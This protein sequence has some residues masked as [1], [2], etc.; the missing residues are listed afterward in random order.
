MSEN[1]EKTNYYLSV[2]K[3]NGLSR[4]KASELMDTLSPEKIEKIEN[5]KQEPTPADIM[6]MAKGYGEPSI[7]NYYCAHDCPMGKFYVREI[8]IKELEKTVLQMIASLNAMHGLQERLISISADGK[9]DDKEIRDFVRI[10]KELERISMS[11]AS[12]QLWAEKMLTIG[13]INME[14]YNEILSEYTEE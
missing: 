11:T 7:R 13:A 3:K 5:G 8:E 2:R 10:Q 1:T 4:E 12:M 6:E 14:K 9:I